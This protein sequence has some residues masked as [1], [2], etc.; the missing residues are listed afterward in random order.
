MRWILTLSTN[1][2]LSSVSVFVGAFTNV[3]EGA[4]CFIGANVEQQTQNDEYRFP[5]KI[6]A[7]LCLPSKTP[8]LTSDGSR[9]GERPQGEVPATTSTVGGGGTLYRA[10]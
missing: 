8:E 3:E 6:P 7:A 10:E 5:S 4:S 9:D 1:G 2:L